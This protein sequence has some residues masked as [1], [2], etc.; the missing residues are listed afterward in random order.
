M[1]KP[2][3]IRR[4]P[5]PPVVLPAPRGI[6]GRIRVAWLALLVLVVAIQVAGLGFVLYDAYRINPALR[7]VGIAL[8]FGDDNRPIVKPLRRDIVAAGVAHG[9][10]I[11]AVAG[12]RIGSGASALAIERA[13]MAAPGDTVALGF[14]KPDGREVRTLASRS[15]RAPLVVPLNPMSVNL[16]MAIRLLSTSLCSI[17]LI[18]SSLILLHRRPRDPEALLL[19]LGFLGIAASMDPPMLMWLS[20]GADRLIDILTGIWWTVLAIALAAFPDGR[21]TPAWLRWSVVV[22]PVLGLILVL[23]RLGD[24]TTLGIGIAVPL[25]LVAA[26]IARY[27]RLEPG[28]RRQQIKWAALGFAAGFVLVGASAIMAQVPYD[29]WTAAA[30]GAWLLGVVCL[31]NLGFA[32]MPLGLL[33]SL[34]RYRLWDVDRIISRSVAYTVLTSGV[35]LLW[36]LLSDAA[37]QIVAMLL[38]QEHAVLGLALGAIVTAGV[39]L[40]TQ[41][42]VLQWS[43]RRFNRSSVDLERLPERLRAWQERCDAAEVATRALDV[44]MRGLHA[45]AGAVFARTPAGRTLLARHSAGIED[46]GTVTADMA[47]AGGGHVVHLEDED[48][49]AGWLVL[50]PRDDGS[51]FP[52]GDLAAL[53]A[54]AAPLARALRTA[55]PAKQRDAAMLNLL[56]QVQ[57][58]LAK[59]EQQNL[60]PA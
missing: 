9:D 48:G 39:F 51:R 38:G 29:D 49:L 16:R 36:A 43:K 13:I 50:M 35:G 31:F 15:S 55:A 7:Q 60:R 3:E 27:R 8:E 54:A 23:D 28:V 33:V 53:D 20:I 34:V 40:P 47:K 41:H 11:V 19:G 56:D 5:W 44:A 59:L 42:L 24:A 57:Q 1:E 6:A 32:V 30:R 18:G 12:R 52:R 58:R 25:M 26:Q 46:S 10:R 45:S 21:F 22:A 37:K 2:A 4:G 14:R 17:A